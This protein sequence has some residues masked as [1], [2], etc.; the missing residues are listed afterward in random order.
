M[1]RISKATCTCGGEVKEVDQTADES[2]TH[3][4]P[5]GCCGT[6]FECQKCKVRFVVKFES[7][8]IEYD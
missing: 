4:C 6:A 8:E 7:P 3:N 2:R 5:R 1:S